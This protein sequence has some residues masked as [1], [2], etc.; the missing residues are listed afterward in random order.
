M[1]ADTSPDVAPDSP[2]P[3]R[4]V[5]A[6][7]GRPLEALDRAAASFGAVMVYGGATTPEAIEPLAED[8]DAMIVFRTPV[9]AAAIS[10]MKRCRVIVRQGIG[11]DLVDVAAATDAGIFVSNVPDYCVEEVATHAVAMLLS[12][13]RDLPGFDRTMREKGW[14]V[15]NSTR[16]VPAL[17]EMRLGIVGFGKIGRSVAR[18]A[19]A[20]GM[21]LVGYDP[22]V[23][24]DVFEA[25]GVRRLRRLEELIAASDAITLHVPATAETRGMWGEREF[26]AMRSGSY[27]VNTARGKVVRQDALER[28]LREGPLAAAALD[29][30]ESEP[31]ILGNPLLALPNLL[32]SPHVAYYSDRSVRVVVRETMEEVGRALLG[33]RPLNLVNPEVFARRR[34]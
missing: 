18:K 8:A 19:A 1:N 14:G 4:V 27:L 33:E 23:H 13:V 25:F 7:R 31:A 12:I 3:F 6:D 22:Y 9:S 15:W 30:F 5:A 2:R 32:L 16:P 21:R 24:D 29:V 28:A 34:A 11:F 20:F 17:D 26:A 10:R